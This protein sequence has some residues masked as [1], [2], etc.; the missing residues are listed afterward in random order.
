[1]QVL[2]WGTNDFGQLGTGDTAYSPQPRHTAG[3]AGV[4][5]ADVAAEGWHSLAL[6]VEGEV[7]TWGRGEYGRLG[8]NDPK[9]AAQVRPKLV[10]GLQG[11]R[12]IQVRALC[13]WRMRCGW[14]MREDR[15]AQVHAYTVQ[16]LLHCWRTVC[17]GKWTGCR[18]ASVIQHTLQ[19]V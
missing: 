10:P 1:V 11:H 18:C 6:S 17:S 7:Y 5:V 2:A 9:G 4:R 16:S 12:I 13:A 3:L 15:P 14:V 19:R 8:L